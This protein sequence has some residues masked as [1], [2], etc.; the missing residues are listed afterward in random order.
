MSKLADVS[1]KHIVNDKELG[2]EAEVSMGKSYPY[3]SWMELHSH[4]SEITPDE[5]D[6]ISQDQWAVIH[7][8]AMD[9]YELTKP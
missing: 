4:N 7:Q 1:F 6:Q 5:Y 2:V 9:E 8:A 3:V